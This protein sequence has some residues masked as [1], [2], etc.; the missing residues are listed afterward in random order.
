MTTTMTQTKMYNRLDQI[1]LK[2]RIQ[3]QQEMAIYMKEIVAGVYEDEDPCEEVQYEL[4]KLDARLTALISIR[5]H[6]AC[7]L[8]KEAKYD[9]LHSL[10]L[11]MKK[12]F[13]NI[14]D[15]ASEHM[16]P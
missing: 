9:L 2:H 11:H 4:E 6:E 10:V 1:E 8:W 5:W 7:M 14:V 12:E 3:E 16:D 15:I 13:E